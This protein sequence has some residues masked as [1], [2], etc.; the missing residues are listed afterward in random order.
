MALTGACSPLP[1]RVTESLFADE[2][3]PPSLVP[4]NYWGRIEALRGRLEGGPGERVMAVDVVFAGASDQ[5][6]PARVRAYGQEAGEDEVRTTFTLDAEDARRRWPEDYVG[7]AAQRSGVALRLHDARYFQNGFAAAEVTFAG[8]VPTSAVATL[9]APQQ[10]PAR[11]AWSARV[12]PQGLAPVL[13]LVRRQ[14]FAELA[15]ISA[16]G[17]ADRCDPIA[18]LGPSGRVLDHHDV[19]L[20]LQ[21]WRLAD[22][23]G[24]APIDVDVADC[25]L[26]LRVLHP[27][28]RIDHLRVPLALLREGDGLTL[29]RRGDQ[30]AWARRDVWRARLAPTAGASGAWPELGLQLA[31]RRIVYG[32]DEVVTP[33]RVGRFLYRALLAPVA[34]ALDILG[35]TN[36]VLGTIINWLFAKPQPS[37]RPYKPSGGNR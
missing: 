14:S 18:W 9:V 27:D 10:V 24:S 21:P 29:A 15:G 2:P 12:I 4:G 3:V 28:G 25:A 22:E 30:V 7:D 1:M 26:L 31:S 17:E 11:V 32:F 16:T 5:R 13:R 6:L 37:P 23:P 36:P 34:V 33:S 8:T 20:L 35:S 19:L